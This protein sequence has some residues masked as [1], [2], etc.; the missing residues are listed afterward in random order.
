MIA[1]GRMTPCASPKMIELRTTSAGMR[2]N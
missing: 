1:I 2:T